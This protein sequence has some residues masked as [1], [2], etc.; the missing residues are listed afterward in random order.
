[1][2]VFFTDRMVAESSSFSPSAHKPR[3][4]VRSWQALGIPLELVEPEAV[5]ID[6]FALAHDRAFVEEVLSCERRNGFGNRSRAIA[7][8]LPY[9]SGSMLA[10]ARSAIHDGGVAVAPCSG[11]HHAGR[12]SVGGFCTFNGLMVTACVLRE[13]GLARQV[14]IL[15]F[16]QHWGDGTEEIVTTLGASWVRHYS[17]G[18][19][20]HSPNQAERFL[21]AIP[22][23]VET[24]SDCDVILYQAGADPHIDD[25]LG[26]WLTLAQLCERDRIVFE[27]ARRYG[28]PIAWNL[29]GGYQDPLRN[30]LDIHD[31]TMIECAATFG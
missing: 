9:T 8:S 18:A 16:D 3:A 12:E 14:G 24:M 5:T 20:W 19:I 17:A 31:N 15:D 11:F 4:V 28:V 26:G 23:I 25:P 2:R 21:E 7:A 27:Q 10:A 6:Q 30:V 22:K 29:A 1:M 13:E